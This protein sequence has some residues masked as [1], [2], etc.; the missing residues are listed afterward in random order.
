[1]ILALANCGAQQYISFPPL[2]HRCGSKLGTQ[3]CVQKG[4]SV[5]AFDKIPMAFT[6]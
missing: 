1:M 5:R 3:E 2:S 4:E 6:L